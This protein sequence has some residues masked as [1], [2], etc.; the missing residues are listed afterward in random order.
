M[1]S[2]GRRIASRARGTNGRNLEEAV[3]LLINNQAHFLG[4]AARIEGEL[5]EIKSFLIHHQRTLDDLQ[6]ILDDLPEAIRQ[7]IGFK[8]RA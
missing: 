6:R 4:V 7:K 5:A 2:Q 3:A 8:P 1:V